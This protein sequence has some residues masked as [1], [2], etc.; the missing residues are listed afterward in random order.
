MR[1]RLREKDLRRLLARL[2]NPDDDT[3]QLLEIVA[4]VPQL[5]S[6]PVLSLANAGLT[7]PR[8]MAKVAPHDQGRA[9]V[10]RGRAT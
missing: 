1:R 7:S 3:F 5:D 10:T 4:A 9:H 8:Q 6:R 2:T